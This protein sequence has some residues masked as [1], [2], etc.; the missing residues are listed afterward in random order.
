MV[1]IFGRG[2]FLQRYVW[3]TFLRSKLNSTHFG[4]VEEAEY[5]DPIMMTEL[6]TLLQNAVPLMLAEH[7]VYVEL[8]F[9]AVGNDSQDGKNTTADDRNGP[10]DLAICS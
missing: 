6:R 7:L 2:D 8:S 3:P 9:T 5:Y 4:L 10:P 1:V